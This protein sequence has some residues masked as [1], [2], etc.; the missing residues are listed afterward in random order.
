[1]ALYYYHSVNVSFLLTLP[2]YFVTHAKTH[3]KLPQIFKMES[4]A[5]IVKG[6]QP[7]TVFAK[8]SISDVSHV[9]QVSNF[10]VSELWQV[11]QGFSNAMDFTK[12]LEIEKKSSYEF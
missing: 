7:L 1:M 4:F 2:C 10:Q 5:K 6:F 8:L 11:F 12:K 3:L 9:L